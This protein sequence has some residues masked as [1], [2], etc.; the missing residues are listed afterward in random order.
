[1]SEKEKKQDQADEAVVEPRSSRLDPKIY[2]PVIFCPV[3]PFVELASRIYNGK[4]AIRKLEPASVY[5]IK[6]RGKK[7]SLV[8]P[9]MGA[10]ASVYVLERLIANGAKNIIMVGLCGSIDSS[11]K[12]GDIFVPSAALIEEGTSIHYN[13][14]TKKALPS[15]RALLS[16]CDALQSSGKGYHTGPV[17]TTDGIYRETKKKVLDYGQRG[18]LAVE[19]EVSALFTVAA[20]RGIDLASILIVS[21]ELFDLRWKTGFT[22]PRFISAC[23]H[24][25]KISLTAAKNLAPDNDDIEDEIAEPESINNENADQGKDSPPEEET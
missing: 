22:R 13:N 16:V 25:A 1:M 21:D 2:D 3:G 17:W 14:K 12:I 6:H 15:E 8:G 11:L 7:M 20:Y 24:A 18:I 19:M 9:A 23:R 4:K 5:T 10:P